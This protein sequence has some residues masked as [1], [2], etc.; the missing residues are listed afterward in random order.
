MESA[1]A[2]AICLPPPRSDTRVVSW[3]GTSLGS[4][5]MITR[6]ARLALPASSS[7][8]MISMLA[9]AAAQQ[10]PAAAIPHG[11]GGND[12]SAVLRKIE[13]RDAAANIPPKANW[14]WKNY[15]SPDL[16]RG[17][18]AIERMLERFKDFCRIAPR[19]DRPAQNSLAASCLAATVYC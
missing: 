7:L 8:S 13:S 15:F 12:G 10:M 2:Q 1:K 14:R 5:R 18:N 4:R 6:R 16:Y 19:Y 3:D 17:R 9:R 11:A